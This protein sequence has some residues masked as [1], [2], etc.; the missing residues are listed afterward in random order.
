MDETLRKYQLTNASGQTV[1]RK[2]TAEDAKALGAEP[3][4]AAPK[5][6]A[7]KTPANKARTPRNK[8]KS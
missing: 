6:K 2:L 1:V 5:K 8:A 4:E 7:A 3:V